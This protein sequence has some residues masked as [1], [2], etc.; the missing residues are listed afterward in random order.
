M[1][2]VE[3]VPLKGLGSSSFT[4]EDKDLVSRGIDVWEYHTGHKRIKC[5]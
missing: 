4:G 5:R 1:F 2:P 3:E